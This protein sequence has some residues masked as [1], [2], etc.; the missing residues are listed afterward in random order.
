[1]PATHAGWYRP[2]RGARIPR[3]RRV[4]RVDLAT[5]Q[6]LAASVP[7]PLDI[8]QGVVVCIK[9]HLL[10]G[11]PMDGVPGRLRRALHRRALAFDEGVEEACGIKA[12]VRLVVVPV[13]DARQIA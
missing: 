10:G 1:G 12:V 5:S 8:G 6:R 2:A 3:V 11:H 9:N 7:L 4:A 13:L